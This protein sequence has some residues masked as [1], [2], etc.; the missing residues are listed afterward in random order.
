V[1]GSVSPLRGGVGRLNVGAGGG[2]LFALSC[3]SRGGG[4]ERGGMTSL[5]VLGGVGFRGEEK[6]K[7]K[8]NWRKKSTKLKIQTL[9]LT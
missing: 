1:D 3:C 5:G 2:G 9:P 6:K 7:K 8:E 4:E